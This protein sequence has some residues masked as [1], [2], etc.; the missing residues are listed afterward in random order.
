MA[1]GNKLFGERIKF[2]RENKN[3]TQEKMAEAI[4]LEYQTISRI[5]TGVNFTSF[6]TLLKIASVLNVEIKDL[7]DFNYMQPEDVLL[8]KIIQEL[9]NADIDELRFFYSMVLNFPRN[10]K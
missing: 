8:D 4:G 6:D 3:L 10:N 1:T 2:I 9:K 7:F 5:E